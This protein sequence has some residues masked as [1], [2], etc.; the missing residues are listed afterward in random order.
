MSKLDKFFV[1]L[2]GFFGLIFV[3]LFL[4]IYKT[5]QHSV[6]IHAVNEKKI[7]EIN[8]KQ[9][10]VNQNLASINQTFKKVDI[11]FNKGFE[12]ISILEESTDPKNK[13][14]AKIKRVRKAIQ[15]QIEENSYINVPNVLGLTKIASSI[16]EYSE[17]YDVSISL[18]LAVIKRESA[19]NADAK[20]RANAIGLMQVIPSTAEE[21]AGDLGIRHYN[22]FKIDT[23]IRFGTWYLWKM[24]DIFEGKV[25]L[26]LRAYN[27]GPVCVKR[28]LSGEHKDY[29]RE[30]QRYVT[31][32]LLW[33]E[34]FENLGL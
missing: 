19:F 11:N 7:D 2:C 10:M 6:H 18:I 5:Y 3:V 12:R 28:V 4:L 24:M 33:T 22:I 17:Q 26:A 13:R 34:E 23:N 16:I 14:W 20:S 1:G 32:V 27:C 15:L 8:E 21:I 9:K 30:T 31:T 25:D 29:P